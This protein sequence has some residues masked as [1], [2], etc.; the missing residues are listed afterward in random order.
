MLHKN[1]K[2]S[3]Q[4]YYCAHYST[5][6]RFSFQKKLKKREAALCSVGHILLYTL[7]KQRLTRTKALVLVLALVLVRR[8]F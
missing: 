8:C 4:E 6:A 5:Q 3:K 1:K 2:K 7:I